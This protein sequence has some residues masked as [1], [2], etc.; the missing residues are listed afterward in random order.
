VIIDLTTFS[1][2]DAIGCG[3]ALRQLGAAAASLEEVAAQLVRYLY[4]HLR[5]AETGEPACVLVRCLQIARYQALRS[6]LQAAVRCGL[7]GS[8]S[9]TAQSAVPGQDLRCLTLLSTAGRLPDGRA[10]AAALGDRVV[11]LADRAAVQQLPLLAQ[12][13]QQFGLDV[14]TVLAA[15]SD[16]LP[17]RA[18]ICGVLYVSQ[19]K[20]DRS[21][22]VLPDSI[23]SIVGFGGMLPSGNLVAV[24]LFSSV[25]VARDA[26][27]GFEYLGLS[28]K[29]ALLPFDRTV[30]ANGLLQSQAVAFEQLLE[31]HEQ[32]RRD[33]LRTVGQFRSGVLPQMNDGMKAAL[34][35]T[36]AIN[37]AIV[38]A[39][40]DLMFRISRDGVY[41]NVVPG[42][43][44]N[45]LY[46]ADQLIGKS[47]A[48]VVPLE[49]A[50][51]ALHH[52]ERALQTD[53][54]QVFEYQ[55]RVANELRDYEA[56]IVAIDADE[57]LAI[58]RD[59]TTAKRREAVRLQ[60]EASQQQ[61]EAALSQSEER[62][63]SLVQNSSDIV[64]VITPDGNRSYVSSS[65]QGILGYQPED[66]IGKNAF[67]DV[68]PDDVAATQAA[69]LN[70]LQH[71][72]QPVRVE[73]RFRHI[74]G[75]WVDLECVGNNLIANPAVGGVVVNIR[76]VSD[77]KR[78]EAELRQ[79]NETLEAQVA[80]RTAELQTFF[81]T[82]PDYIYVI[83]RERMRLLFCND[84]LASTVNA[85][86]R[87]EIQGKT[88][89][90]VFTPERA[91]YF[92]RQNLQ[93]F[94]SGETLHVE[95]SFEL[96]GGKYCVD[97]YKVP[98]KK[99]NGEVYALIGTS[100][101]IHKLV[102]VQ[103]ALA[104]RTLEL[105][106]TNQELNSFAYSV[107]HDLRAPLR[108]INGFAGFLRQQLVQSGVISAEANTPQSAK[109]A[110]YLQIIQDSSLNMGRLIDGLLTLS[111]T[112]RQQMQFRSTSLRPLVEQ[113]IA[114]VKAQ[115][116]DSADSVEFTIEELSTVEAD[117]I[118]LQQV[119]SNLID[120]AVKFSRQHPT[121]QVAIG[122]L[123][124]GTIFVRDNGVGFSM[125]YADQLFGAF[126]RLHSQREFE[127]TGIGLEIVQ[128]IV[129][130]HGGTIWA[131]SE[132]GQGACFYLRLRDEKEE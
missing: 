8:Q 130:R 107:S 42:K 44:I 96:P 58:V 108:H 60:A 78:V 30:S 94:E 2:E 54:L 5:D 86:S 32:M 85:A 63:R 20:G 103:E 87:Y 47:L 128:R 24:V 27:K 43:G 48:E 49:V 114:L 13:I 18:H 115:A 101:D 126:H 89:F 122:T 83:D 110:Q 41:L 72:E 16:G 120:N 64:V 7:A 67:S 37:Q 65:V 111:R 98:L 59:I 131:T 45:P 121:P 97:T 74:N 81:D 73:F 129:H 31:V 71:P 116:D 51:Q 9:E 99:S 38:S 76:D 124:D 11:P 15:D 55:L 12:L 118:L 109:I 39:I 127:G 19:V 50:Q 1:L 61:V 125:K 46:A 91:A 92:A 17:Q 53:A 80:L 70:T 14:D 21:A 56:R 119:F 112:G 117:P 95:E 77:R 100:R 113:S 3:D 4:D 66:L 25:C 84:L 132:P 69:F 82:L 68:H 79:L 10:D 57:V 88:I 123:P 35:Q 93:V 102:Q 23:R 52:I 106:A 22:V 6:D 104:A 90:E 28:T 75:D 34:L 29:L 62:F 105:E 26:L 33:R 36:Q 40:P